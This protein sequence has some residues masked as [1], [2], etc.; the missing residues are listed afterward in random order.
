MEQERRKW[1]KYNIK[2]P[3]PPDGHMGSMYYA[4]LVKTYG[5]TQALK[6]YKVFVYKAHH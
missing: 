4:I 1:S 2:S 6:I 5:E 3:R